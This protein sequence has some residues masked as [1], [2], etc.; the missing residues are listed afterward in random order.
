M[1][2]RSQ[3]TCK[4]LTPDVRVAVIVVNYRTPS[5]TLDAVR[6][7]VG[8]IDRRLDR[9][10]VVDNASG[11]GSPQAIASELEREG[12]SDVV[13][14][15]E[16]ARNGGF[17]AGN[18]AGM[19]T[20]PAR[21]YLLLNSDASMRPGALS[22]LLAAAQAC[23][24]AG[25]ISPR[26][27]WP[28][29]TPQISCFRFP[30]PPTEAVLASGTGPVRRLLR[31]WDVPLGLPDGPRPVPWTSFAAA[32][33]RAEALRDV[34][35]L[36]EGYFMYFEDAAFC[37]AARR[38]GWITLHWPRAAVVH[39]RG[40]TSPVKRSAARR[41]RLPRYFYAARS[42]YYRSFYGRSGLLLA[43]LFWATGYG[44][45][46]ARELTEGRPPHNGPGAARDIWTG[47]LGGPA[48]ASHAPS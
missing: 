23:P 21:F 42:H 19:G 2:G 45:A 5:M 40:G 33:I 25:V 20:C 18:N 35:G 9:I 6:S 34:G 8:E 28:D 26:L 22:A 24:R 37:R 36:D 17:A 14:V 39:L 1:S 47:F 12:W 10:V 44:I 11:D 7:A 43:N 27:T 13:R 48:E 3:Q 16:A 30:G 4:A 41:Q 29:G 38:A 31:R 15:I 46:R 32:L